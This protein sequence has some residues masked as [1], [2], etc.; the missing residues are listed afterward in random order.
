MHPFSLAKSQSEQVVGGALVSKVTYKGG[1]TESG[2]GIVPTPFPP[3][4]WQ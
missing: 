3:K 4:D 1:C 2:G